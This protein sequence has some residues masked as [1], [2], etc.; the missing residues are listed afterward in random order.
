[1]S[2]DRRQ[3]RAAD[4]A[5]L[6]SPDTIRRLIYELYIEQGRLLTVARILTE[7]GYRTRGGGAWSDTTIERLIRDPI[8]KGTRRS[9]YT[10]SRGQGKGWNLK[11]AHEW[12][13]SEVEPVVPEELWSAA[14]ALLEEKRREKK[15]AARRPVHLFAG[16]TLCHCGAKMY[17]PA[18]TPKY[19]CT[20]KGCR[21]K[22]PQAD[23]ERVF[24]EQLKQFFLSPEE[25]AGALREADE[26][27]E[28]KADLL[29][30][31]EREALRLKA[32]ADQVYHLYL[33]GE[34]DPRGFGERNT[35]IEKRRVELATEMP[36]LQGEID[37]LRIQHLSQ[38]EIIS[39][40]EDLYR[41]WEDLAF[42]E[43]RAIVQAIVE[44][45]TI[46]EDEIRIALA[47]LPK[48]PPLSPPSL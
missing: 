39:E 18:N 43:R 29:D 26:E 13:T 9:N 30:A 6:R 32:E 16:L 40:A 44:R 3:G 28:A 5:D 21:N 42:D 7:R 2:I 25:V 11:P 23:L 8:A 48:T 20:R 45:V 17:V 14:N 37:F 4:Y 10:R 22:V 15:P 1:M 24:Q 46:G 33:A 19:V 34:I 35:P 38:E 31:M 12:V 47:C 41:R 27:V 36:R